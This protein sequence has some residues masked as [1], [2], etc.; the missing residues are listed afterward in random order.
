MHALHRHRSAAA[1]AALSLA[2]VLA[3]TGCGADA[4]GKTS[5]ADRAAV[6]PAP[7]QDGKAPQGAEGA[8][9]AAAPPSAAPADKNA[10]PAAPVRPN[11][12][13]T[14]TLGIE[15]TDAQ[16]ALAAARAAADG[17]GG[18]VGN[19]STKRGQDGRMTSTV[20]LRVPGERYDSVLSAMEGSGK[21][22]HRK[23]DAQ[24]VTEKVA[25]IGSRVASQQASVARVR[26]MMGK[27]T[28]LSD[29]VMLESELSRRQSDLES[30]QA[31]QTA[32]RDQTSMGTITLEVTEPAPK[33]E[34]TEKKE[35]EPT[36]LDALHGGWE[37]FT[38]VVRYLTVAV[39]ALLPFALTAALVLALVRLYRRRRPARPKAAQV[40]A[41]AP[42]R[43]A[44]QVPAAQVP[45]PRSPAPDTE[46]D[47]QD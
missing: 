26:E 5:S 33:P 35:K 21:L 2:G 15:T 6:A 29:V 11:V 23:V 31:Q 1:L 17:A 22:L 46:A 12:I 25:D 3:L 37:V 44:A 27:A 40:T 41:A 18:Y 24:D 10:P 4:G 45:A 32:L 14:A 47:V 28:A 16:K 43:T 9:G 36:F 38:T 19:E 34:V 13:R 8:K 7:A 42:Q 30:L 20:T 39:G